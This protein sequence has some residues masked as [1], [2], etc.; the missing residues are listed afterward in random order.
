ML[1]VNSSEANISYIVEGQRLVSLH[2]CSDLF[3]L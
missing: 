3:G 1:C 2:D